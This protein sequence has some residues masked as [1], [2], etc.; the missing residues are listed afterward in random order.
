MVRGREVL[1]GCV[2]AW[3]WKLNF[4]QKYI[5]WEVKI[6]GKKLNVIYSFVTYLNATS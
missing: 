4:L 3:E 1:L 6:P 5:T 2:V